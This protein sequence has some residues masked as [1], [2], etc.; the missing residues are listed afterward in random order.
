M[1][2]AQPQKPHI[3]KYDKSKIL[4][5]TGRKMLAKLG[6]LCSLTLEELITSCMVEMATPA[7][8]R[9][10]EVARDEVDRNEVAR[11][12]VPGMRWTGMRWPGMRWTW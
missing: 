8:A 12:E 2:P 1:T 3:V 11:D 4:D 10:Q 6:V 5:R 9:W 7:C